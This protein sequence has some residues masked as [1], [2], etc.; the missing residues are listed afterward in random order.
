MPVSVDVYD[1]VASLFDL[2]DDF[3]QG[4]EHVG[5]LNLPVSGMVCIAGAER[6]V[7]QMA[8]QWKEA[9]NHME[10]D[11]EHRNSLWVQFQ[12]TANLSLGL[13]M[14][15]VKQR[16]VLGGQ[17]SDLVDR[18]VSSHEKHM[19]WGLSNISMFYLSGEVLRWCL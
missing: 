6:P 19:I 1:H 3:V 5:E 9:W 16:Q 2:L 4:D 11:H 12:H 10:S 18:G 15:P 8:V 14:E 13:V 17:V 7:Q